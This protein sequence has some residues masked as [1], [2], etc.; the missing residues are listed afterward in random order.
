MQKSGRS[1]SKSPLPGA[2]L[3][4]GKARGWG[5]PNLMDRISPLEPTPPPLRGEGSQ[6]LHHPRGPSEHRR[7]PAVHLARTAGMSR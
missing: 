3:I 7:V 1:K 5:N 4:L 6:G 2:C